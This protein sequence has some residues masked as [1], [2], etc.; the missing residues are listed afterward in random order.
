MILKMNNKSE[1]FYSVMG[2][3]FG[4]RI[5]EH[6]TN[7]RIYDDNNKEWYIYFDN[8]IPVAFV[9][10][11]SE[12]I[13]NIYSINDEFLTELLTYVRKETKVK[14]SIVTNAYSDIYNSCGFTCS[15]DYG[16]KN[17]VTI[18]SDLNG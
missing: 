12:V 17:F 2:K 16:Y 9:S 8:D 11:S 14:N 15:N 13:K 18:R 5:V 6:K 1:N 4:S 10:I 7:D 3:F